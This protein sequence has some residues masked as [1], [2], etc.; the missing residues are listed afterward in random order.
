MFQ[1]AFESAKSMEGWLKASMVCKRTG[2]QVTWGLCRLNLTVP[3]ELGCVVQIA[4]I[5]RFNT[6]IK[7]SKVYL[8]TVLKRLTTRIGYAA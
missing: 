6:A 5:S 8:P 4:P 7:E 2:C 3:T 1:P